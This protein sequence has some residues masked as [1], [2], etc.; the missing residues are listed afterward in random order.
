M[1]RQH[2]K[3]IRPGVIAQLKETGEHVSILKLYRNLDG[4]HD[5]DIFDAMFPNK[6]IGR[7]ARKEL[8]FVKVIPGWKGEG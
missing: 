7:Y 1:S 6:C 8:S 3:F 4:H 2:P 5:I